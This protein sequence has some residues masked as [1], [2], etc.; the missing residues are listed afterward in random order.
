MIVTQEPEQP[1]NWLFVEELK[2]SRHEKLT[3]GRIKKR[4][5]EADLGKGVILDFRFPDEG[6]VLDTAIAD[7]HAFLKAAGIPENGQFKITVERL[8]NRLRVTA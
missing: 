4:K 7:F 8:Q 6:K 5:N 3:W 2:A 1:K